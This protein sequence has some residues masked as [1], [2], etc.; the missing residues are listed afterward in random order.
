MFEEILGSGTKIRLLRLLSTHP[1]REFTTREL[2]LAVGQSL[3][4]V[5]P[6]LRQLWDARAVVTRRVGRSRVVRINRAH[7]LYPAMAALFREES[8]A[9]T[10]VAREFAD[11][12]PRQGVESAVLFGSVARGES[13]ARS[14]VDVL[15]VVGDPRKGS[16]VQKAA[17]TI[18]DRYDANVSPLVLTS[19]EVRRR[20]KAFDPL[21][22]TIAAE[23]RL[24]RGRATWLGR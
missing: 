2:A 24:L 22:Q 6:A 13:D 18:L 21:L 20:L 5:H 19:A 14:D 17:A 12:L 11:I 7:P 16:A 3:G 23:G 1:D 8:S 10:R 4:S 9:L 15:V